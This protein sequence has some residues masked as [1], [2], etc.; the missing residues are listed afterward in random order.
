MTATKQDEVSPEQRTGATPMGDNSPEK[1][2]G[3]IE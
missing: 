2:S 1:N 3:K